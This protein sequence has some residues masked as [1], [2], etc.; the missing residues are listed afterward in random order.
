MINRQRNK[1]R[2]LRSAYVQI[3]DS[4]EK[5]RPTE[6]LTVSLCNSQARHT[7]AANCVC[8]WELWKYI[9]YS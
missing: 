1:L 2:A 4:V 7:P 9:Y 8:K 3:I 5:S 6:V